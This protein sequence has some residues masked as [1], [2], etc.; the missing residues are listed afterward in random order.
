MGIHED[1]KA[2]ALGDSQNLDRVLN[3][4]LIVLARSS[5]LDRLPHEHVSNRV[6]SVPLDPRKVHMRIV[7]R[8]RPLV[9]IDIVAVE[10]LVLDVGRNIGVAR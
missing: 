10:K 7:L 6:E 4:F 9:E 3:E 5:R 1:V 8:K 2:I